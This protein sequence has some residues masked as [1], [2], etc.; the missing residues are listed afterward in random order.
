MGT[1]RVLLSTSYLPN[2][3]YLAQVIHN[4]EVV[5]ET[6]E[7]FVK[8]TYRSRCDILSSNGKLSLSIPLVK[9]ADKEIITE[10]KISYAENWQQQHWRSI[11]SAYKNSPYFEFFEDELKPFYHQKYEYLFDYNLQLLKT[12]LHILRV[13]KEFHSTEEFQLKPNEIKDLRVLSNPKNDSE[14]EIKPYYQLFSSKYG[15]IP[16]LSC[17]DAVFNEGLYTLDLLK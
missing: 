2:L 1:E 16:N 15:F 17:I 8:Q 5:F 4:D 3:P 10:K 6:H 9:Q 12:V 14:F 7:Y 11:T 13:K